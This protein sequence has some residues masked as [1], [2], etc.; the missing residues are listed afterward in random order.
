MEPDFSLLYSLEPATQPPSESDQCSPCPSSHFLKIRCNITLPSTPGSSKWT[1]S[2]RL[3]HQMPVCNSP[4]THT[5][6][7]PPH[8]ILPDLIARIILGEGYRSLSSSLCSFLHSPVTS[9]LLGSDILLST[10]F[11]NTLSLRSPLIVSDHNSHP[12]KT[13]G[14]IMV[15]YV[16]IFILLD[17]KLEDKIF[18]AECKQTFCDF[19]LLLLSSSVIPN[20]IKCL[21]KWV[22]RVAKSAFQ[23]RHVGPSVRLPARISVAPTAPTSDIFDTAD[24]YGNLSINPTFCKNRAK[25]SGT[26]QETAV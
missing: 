26:L 19:P 24:F 18:C 2:I 6:Y 3:P 13:T 10:L 25:L 7:M 9:F 16:L 12:Y 4:L 1:P 14:P 11:S 20:I 8:L 5:C 23:L 22:R 15:L 17:N 21:F